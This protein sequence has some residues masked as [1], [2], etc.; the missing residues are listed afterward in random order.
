[1]LDTNIE[2]NIHVIA[3]RFPELRESILDT[4]SRW[5]EPHRHWHGMS[6]LT[7]CVERSMEMCQEYDRVFY[8]LVSLYHDAVYDPTRSD[9]E[10]ESAKLVPDFSIVVDGRELTGESV[11]LAVLQTKEDLYTEFNRIDRDILKTESLVELLEYEKG[12][13]LE[14]Q[15]CALSDYVKGRCDFLR[16]VSDEW[17]TDANR[18]ALIEYVTKRTY[19]IGIYAGSFDPFHVGHNDIRLQAEKH[20]DKVVVA[21][22]TN[23]IKSYSPDRLDNVRCVLP[24]TQVLQYHGLLSELCTDYTLQAEN[25][26]IT[27][28]RGLRNITDLQ[29]EQNLRA[30]LNDTGSVETMYFMCDPKHQHVSSSLV[31]E[32]R[33]FGR[34]ADEYLVR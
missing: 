33:S 2:T 4:L 18:N 32:L 22:G 13:F 17:I 9:N 1:M 3:E 23:G 10:E 26:E 29:Y 31:R 25:V 30:A 27:L 15:H 21:L 28:V 16:G 14:F 19:R 7:H 20:F 11:R 34:S 24:H 8:T 12:I 5:H 6:H